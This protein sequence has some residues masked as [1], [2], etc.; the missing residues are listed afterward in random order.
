[1]ITSEEIFRLTKLLMGKKAN[2]KIKTTK[3]KRIYLK[4]SMKV[5]KQKLSILL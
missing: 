2:V 1:M 4:S 5:S 3:R